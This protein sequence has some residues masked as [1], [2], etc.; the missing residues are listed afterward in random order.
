LNN[1]EG[2]KLENKGKKRREIVMKPMY[3]MANK[4]YVV[5]NQYSPKPKLQQIQTTSCICN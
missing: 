5:V 3:V 1:D 2:R 4:V